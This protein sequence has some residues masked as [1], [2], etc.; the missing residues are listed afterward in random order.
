MAARMYE[1]LL[2]AADTSSDAQRADAEQ[3]IV[4]HLQSVQTSDHDQSG[5]GALRRLHFEQFGTSTSIVSC[6][7]ASFST[8]FGD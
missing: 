3:E 6:L 2:V 4:R 5:L 1:L 8:H 7:F